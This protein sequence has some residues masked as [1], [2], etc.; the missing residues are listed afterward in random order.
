M[1]IRVTKLQ[2]FPEAVPAI[3]HSGSLRYVFET[4]SNSRTNRKPQV[5][6]QCVSIDVATSYLVSR[7]SEASGSSRAAISDSLL[8]A[9]DSCVQVKHDRRFSSW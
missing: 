7:I 4:R 5:A 6:N 9:R 2:I 8:L 3:E 1:S